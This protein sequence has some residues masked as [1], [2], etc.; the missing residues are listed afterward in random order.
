[1]FILMFIYF[2]FPLVKAPDGGEKIAEM[3][4]TTL[5]KIRSY[6]LAVDQRIR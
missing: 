3:W 5:R 2:V 1:M 4:K 6:N